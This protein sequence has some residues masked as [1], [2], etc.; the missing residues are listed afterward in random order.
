MDDDVFDEAEWIEERRRLFRH[1][2]WGCFAMIALLFVAAVYFM[3][4]PD[5]YHENLGQ[6]QAHAP[7]WPDGSPRTG[8]D[9]WADPSAGGAPPGDER[10]APLRSPGG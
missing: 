5:A 6:Q 10:S 4:Q 3:G 7:R 1:M 9:W 2:V 8:D